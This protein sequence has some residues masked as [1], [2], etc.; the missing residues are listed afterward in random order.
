MLLRRIGTSGVFSHT[1][2]KTT[3]AASL[4]GKRWASDTAWVFEKFGR[5]Q[6]VLKLKEFSH[7]KPE[8][9]QVSLELVCTPVNVADLSTIAGA[10]PL[11]PT[12]P[13]VPGIEGLFKVKEVGASVSALSPGDLVIPHKPTFGTWTTAA[14]APAETLTKVSPKLQPEYAASMAISPSTAL[15]LVED[16]VDLQE[17]DVVIQNCASGMVGQTVMQICNRRGIKTINIVEP[18]DEDALSLLVER[19]KGFGGDLVVPSNYVLTSEFRKLISD[20]PKPKLAL[21]GA[22]GPS[23]TELAR[24][25]GK[26]GTMVSYGA[27]SRKPI[28]I[29]SSLMIFKDLN[30]RG[31]WLHDW[32][33]RASEEERQGMYNQLTSFF[34]DH[35]VKLFIE[36]VKFRDLPFIWETEP[37][38]IPRKFVLVNED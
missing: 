16:F 2:L 8:E 14:V 11:R 15:R 22:G 28:Q 5:C 31:F 23:A 20:M 25:L 35:K 33:Q 36:R 24:L 9:G 13:A 6:D 30:L 29:P 38:E 32:L 19:M 17:G 7:K 34:L 3:V 27:M 37:R 4:Y 18:I 21:D 1:Y 12:P 10:Y 26:G